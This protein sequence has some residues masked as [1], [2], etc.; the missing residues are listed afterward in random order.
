[1]A[2]HNGCPDGRVFPRGVGVAPN[3]A[4]PRPTGTGGV[5]PLW[6]WLTH[7]TTT[8][9]ARLE[10]HISVERTLPGVCTQ[11]HSKCNS[12]WDAIGRPPRVRA[13]RGAL[14]SITIDMCRG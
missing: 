3:R 8:Y 7:D 12:E 13:G 10:T 11:C 5:I 4:A 2:T 6:T 9:L 1:M 14:I